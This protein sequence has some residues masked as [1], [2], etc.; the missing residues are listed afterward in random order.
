MVDTKANSTCSP[1]P[2]QPYLHYCKGITIHRAYILFLYC[3]NFLYCNNGM[4]LTFLFSWHFCF[5]ERHASFLDPGAWFHDWS[6]CLGYGAASELPLIS[7]KYG[8]GVSFK[9]MYHQR[10]K[11][12]LNLS[13]NIKFLIKS[14]MFQWLHYVKHALRVPF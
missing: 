4:K 9:R 6:C 10:I 1:I 2:R 12:I 11:I 8:I 3:P 7:S 5:L 13:T 14:L